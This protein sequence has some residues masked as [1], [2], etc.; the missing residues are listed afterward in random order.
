MASWLFV[1]TKLHVHLYM[2]IAAISDHDMYGACA[3]VY[4]SYKT[5]IGVHEMHG[6]MHPNQGLA[7]LLAHDILS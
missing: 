4:N 5:L 7:N 3:L 1:L 2:R 6:Q